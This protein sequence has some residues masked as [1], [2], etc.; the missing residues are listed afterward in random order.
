MNLPGFKV[1]DGKGFHICFANGYT[2]S[3]QFGYG[4]YCD[5]YDLD[6]DLPWAERHKRENPG[7]T[8]AECA[9]WG[10]DGKMIDYGDWN[11]TVSNRSKPAE[12]LELLNWAA[13][14]PTSAGES[15]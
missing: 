12:V 7:S 8:N 5:N 2:V 13:S 1:T 15:K 11:N 6:Q 4:N 14:Q 10:P 3:V 9:V